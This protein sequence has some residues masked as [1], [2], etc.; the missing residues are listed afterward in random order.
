MVGIVIN[1]HHHNHRVAVITAIRIVIMM[2]IAARVC[3]VFK[4]GEAAPHCEFKL[5]GTADSQTLVS[6]RTGVKTAAQA[7][8]NDSHAA[9]EMS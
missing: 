6:Y 9:G 3:T 1:I 5:R 8:G 4:R 7:F 2:I